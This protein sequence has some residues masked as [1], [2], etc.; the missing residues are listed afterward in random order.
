MADHDETNAPG[1]AEPAGAGGTLDYRLGPRLAR[2]QADLESKSTQGAEGATWRGWLLGTLAVVGITWLIPYSDFVYR[3]STFSYAAFPM[4]SVALTLVLLAGLTVCG[5]AFGLTRQDLTLVFCMT[6]VMYAIPGAGFF[7]FWS[8]QMTA[9]DHYASS[10]NDFENLLLPHQSPDFFVRDPADPNDPGPRP[11]EWFYTGLP[12]GKEIP[13]SAWT[14]PFARWMVVVACMYGLWFAIAGLLIQRWSNQERLAFPVAQVPEVMLRPF[15]D[16]GTPSKP[17]LTDRI[18][19]WGLVLTFLLQSYNAAGTYMGHMPELPLRNWNLQAKYL[20]EPPWNALGGLHM[21]IFP[22]IVGLTFLL[23]LEVAFSLWFFYALQKLANFIFVPMHGAETVDQTYINQG[24]GA[25]LMLVLLGVWA[26]RSELGRS[27]RQALGREPETAQPGDPTSRSLWVLL[28][29][30]FFGAVAW[31]I[32]YG[33]DLGY[34]I[35]MVLLFMIVMTGLARL[36]AE[37]GI[38]A[39]QVYDFPIHLLNYVVPPAAMGAQNVVPLLTFNRVF[40]SDWFRIV[41]LPNIVNGLHLA[42]Q[43][44]LRRKSAMGGIALGVAL[45]LG[46]GFFVVLN[47]TYTSGG[48]TEFGYFYKNQPE[49]DMNSYARTSSR[50]QAWEKKIADTEKEGKQAPESEAPTEARVATSKLAWIG[51][52]GAV[53]SLIM[54]LRQFVFWFPHPAG[55]VMWMASFPIAC[56]WFSFF[57]GW[58]CKWCIAKYG[59]MRVYTA[60]RRFFIGMIVGEALAAAVWGLVYLLA[61]TKDGRA[62]WIS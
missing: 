28:A 57:L 39:A 30:S 46:L 11:V 52:G 48:A 50:V 19:L 12:E 60:A 38:V 20:T 42:G 4:L 15:G 35:A 59:G 54:I 6:M 56:L 49:M 43:L 18:A 23:S 34:A 22:T 5:R 36:V 29:V 45:S 9:A 62:I 2:E 47:T 14:G 24:T 32:W 25:L 58:A 41:P 21:H 37:A 40:T 16:S 44:G 31:L 26:A 3:G 1:T 8:T 33:I 61:G 17:F 51:A 13:W 27:L 7:S 10:A 55:Y 53:M